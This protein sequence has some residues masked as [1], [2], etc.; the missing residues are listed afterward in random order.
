MIFR[1]DPSH[2]FV[3]RCHAKPSR[4]SPSLESQLVPS[5]LAGGNRAL[6]LLDREP[7]VS[8]PVHAARKGCPCGRNYSELVESF[9]SDRFCLAASAFLTCR[10]TRRY[11]RLHSLV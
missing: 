11:P 4:P 8:G 10:P 6:W 3:W 2:L 7:P 1:L 5:L 9:R